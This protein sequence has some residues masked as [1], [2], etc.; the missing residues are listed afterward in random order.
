MKSSKIGR[1][2]K[3][4]KQGNAHIPFTGKLVTANAGIAIIARG[5]ESCGI[6]DKLDNITAH[7]DDGCRHATSKIL[8]Q[9]IALRILGG[10]AVSDTAILDEPAVGAMFGW[11]AIAHQSTFSRRLKQM[12]WRDNLALETIVTEL[13]HR[14]RASGNLLLAI[15]STVDTV[16]GE[17][18]QGA[19]RGYNPHKP[20]RN[21][22]HP[23]LA[24]DVGSRSVVDGY[25]RPG[26]CASNDGLDGFI[27]VDGALID[28]T[29]SMLWAD[30]RKGSK[31]AKVHVGFDLNHSIPK[32]VYL[33]EGNA[34]ERP[35]VS[36]ILSKNQTAVIDRGYQCHAL[37]DQWQ[38][39]GQLFICRIKASTKKKIL[40]SGSRRIFKTNTS[41]C[42]GLRKRR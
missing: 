31:K 28:G 27:R 24:V 25:L 2:R 36:K 3:V 9:L 15:D 16:F 23:L 42:C 18:I 30:Y 32:K 14:V 37:F 21:A 1:R 38:Q 11:D 33:T 26:S 7:L 22:Y 29:L 8:Q 35:F 6:R 40:M 19:E 39:N 4:F 17:K 5:L 12:S 20:G 34:G 41:A 13:S 10:E